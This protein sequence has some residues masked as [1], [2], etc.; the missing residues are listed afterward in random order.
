MYPKQITIQTIK[1]EKPAFSVLF[2]F[3]T[4]V[5]ESTFC[6]WSG[7]AYPVIP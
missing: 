3:V 7:V 5:T 2:G 1:L 4:S 6:V